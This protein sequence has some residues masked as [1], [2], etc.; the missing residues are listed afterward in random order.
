MRTALGLLPVCLFLASLV[1]LDSYKLVRFRNIIGTILA[2]CAA[3][4]VSYGVNVTILPLFGIEERLVTRFAAPLVE[5][6]FKAVPIV[7][8]LRMKRI[9]FLVDAAI[10]GFAI[11][12]GFALLENLYYLTALPESATALWVV[13][14]F[15][16]A[17]MHG[18]TTATF[19]ML[20]QLLAE[21]R[22]REKLADTIPGLLVAVAIHSGFNHFLISPLMSTAL[23][24]IALPSIVIVVFA[25]SER[26]LQAWLGK[27]FD[28]DSELLEL[29]HSGYFS[30]SRVGSYLQSLRERFPG[31]ILADML[32]YLR[33]YAELSLRA[34]GILMMRENGFEIRRDAIIDAKLEELRYLEKS[35]GPTGRLAIA[36]ILHRNDQDIWQLRLLESG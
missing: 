15:G 14:G 16:T 4:I 19:A 5:E 13:R 11:G 1:Y 25:Q 2:G 17:V 20:A 10:Y 9:G 27:G 29:L 24:M 7:L 36:P 26:F 8:L 32:C 6:I 18:G 30:E 21:R 22:G 35:I 34:K 3:A 12:T 31:E 23:V 28:I 33:L